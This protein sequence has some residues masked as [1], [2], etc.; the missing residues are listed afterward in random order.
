[1]GGLILFPLCLG[2]KMTVQ[3]IMS[4]LNSSPQSRTEGQPHP[5]MGVHS[6]APSFLS[7]AR[8]P[9]TPS[10]EA[11]ACDFTLQTRVH[12]YTKETLI[13]A[14]LIRKK[15]VLEGGQR[16]SKMQPREPGSEN[17]H[18]SREAKPSQDAV[19]VHSF[20][21]VQLFATSWS[22]ARQASPSSTISQNLLKFMSV[23][24]VMPSNQLILC[25]PFLLL[26][27][28]F[29]SI[30]VFSNESGGHLCIRWPKYQSFIFSIS[31]SSEYSGLVCF[32]MDWFDEGT[33]KMR[34]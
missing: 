33:A 29:P 9:V 32:R 6:L 16:G 34:A 22:A 21:R 8:L 20:S 12:N 30:S 1:M 3:H 23:E 24:L 11:W 26:P 25:R 18:A 14:F 17:R 2:K 15:N 7:L 19:V 13:L 4:S 5:V 28:I 31:P 27:S 10:K